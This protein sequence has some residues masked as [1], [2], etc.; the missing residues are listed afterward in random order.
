M[1][2]TA[3]GDIMEHKGNV[4]LSQLHDLAFLFLALAHGTDDEL[5]PDEQRKMSVRLRT[6]QPNKDP[7][8][9]DHVIRE[10]ALTYL[11]GHDRDRLEGIVTELGQQLSDDLKLALLSDL[12]EI[13]EADGTVMAAEAGFLQKLA[14]RWSV[15][16]AVIN[17]TG[18][19]A[20]EPPEHQGRNAHQKSIHSP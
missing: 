7:A 14:S 18:D 20:A 12:R 16:I 5:H 10:A 13:A 19:R 3:G 1:N 4:S 2:C 9:I 11:E 8:L 17:P 6:W 15:P